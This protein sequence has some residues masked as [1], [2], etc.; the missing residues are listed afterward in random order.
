MSNVLNL[1][2][3]QYL[4][5]PR[6]PFSASTYR[7]LLHTAIPPVEQETA[8]QILRRLPNSPLVATFIPAVRRLGN[9]PSGDA[10]AQTVLWAQFTTALLSKIAP[11]DQ[12]RIIR[13][14]G[15]MHSMSIAP[16]S[17]TPGLF[18]T[19]RYNAAAEDHDQYP[20]TLVLDR[21]QDSMLGMNFH[22]LPYRLRFALFEALMPLIVPIPVSQ[23]SLINI[24]Y[25]DLVSYGQFR[26]HK[27]TIKRYKLNRIQGQAV[28]ISPIE[29]A[30]AMAYPNHSFVGKRVQE[31]WSDGEKNV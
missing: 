29:W 4:R 22:Y 5:H 11:Q 10:T 27:P 8:S 7:G 13:R 19:Y 18:Y 12:D 31:V 1:F 26:N 6:S 16:R 25:Q 24:V 9:V 30:V 15:K 14:Y 20:L 3:Q 21:D 23:L 2:I 28:F 17:I